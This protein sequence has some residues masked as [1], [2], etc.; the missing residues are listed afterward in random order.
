ME[1]KAFTYSP[2]HV[3]SCQQEEEEAGKKWKEAPE[4]ESGVSA[5]AS[6]RLTAAKAAL[7]LV[8]KRAACQCNKLAQCSR[9]YH[10]SVLYLTRPAQTLLLA[11]C[12]CRADEMEL[13]LQGVLCDLAAASP[14]PL[15]CL[16]RKEVIAI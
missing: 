1:G 5:Q 7:P 14:A 16:P 2:A 9:W 10:A 4:K 6:L 15:K 11:G 3:P 13:L 8:P 12:P